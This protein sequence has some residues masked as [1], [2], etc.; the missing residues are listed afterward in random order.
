LIDRRTLQFFA[1]YLRS[2]PGASALMVGLLVLS[3]VLEGV[4]I[5]SLV[6]LLS[7]VS[8][9]QQERGGSGVHDA[10]ADA[11]GAV[12][13][14]PTIGVLIAVIVV[15][16]SLKAVALWLAMR[17]VG[18]IVARVARDL[19]LA[20]VR[21][22]LRARWGYFGMHPLGR[23]ANA[24]TN[25]TTAATAAYRE[26]CTVLA[27]LLQILMYVTISLLISWQSTAAA[28]IIGGGLF[29][30]LRRFV[31]MSRAA[32]Q[33]QVALNKSLSGRIV[34][35][36]QGIKAIKAMALEDRVLPILE[37]ET[38]ELNVAQQ[39]RV[40]AQE[41]PRI[42]QEPVATLVLGIG[43]YVL[44]TLRSMP[45]GSVLLLAFI[46]QRLIAHMNTL[47]LRYQ[48]VVNGESSFWSVRDQIV[49]AE[50]EA[51][52]AVDSE[53][54]VMPRF[55]R[56][57]RFESVSFGFPQK[58]LFDSLSLTIP[59]GSFVALIGPSGVGKTTIIDLLVGL[60][61]TKAGEIF[62]DDAPL[63][64][65]DM[66]AWRRAIG[67]VPQEML[68][69]NDTI[70]HNITLG[71][72]SVGRERLEWALRAAGAWDFVAERHGGLDGMVGNSG[73]RLS[74]GQRQRLAI[75]RALVRSPEILVL[76]EATTALD[77][78]TE[79]GIFESLERLR[80]VVTIIA[81]SHQPMLRD[82]A[83]IVYHIG[84][85]GITQAARASALDIAVS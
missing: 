8:G 63:S 72:E 77:P 46:F 56:E 15:S 3:G 1:Y 16:M 51:E 49:D 67:Y 35:A 85:D 50:R 68:L 60:H 37:R 17:Q 4:G 78:D 69:F 11:V 81:I 13:L 43:L 20:L 14:Q 54:G 48:V 24:I 53:A 25:E 75:A 40:T 73:S 79:A 64:T 52:R 39:K 34:D 58:P 76:D 61:R 5:L 32:G 22:L 21:A 30:G 41:T 70:E 38:E 44:L 27:A 2:Y 62:I 12:G 80:G 6:P 66:R 45:F 47:H 83:D 9:G 28:L 29:V 74:G 36:L 31:D 82:A 33:A 18:F 10:I 65:V 57:I 84:A 7:V 55:E 71:D 23:F 19:R 26:A 42:I 59:H